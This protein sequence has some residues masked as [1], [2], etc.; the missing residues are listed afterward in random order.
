MNGRAWSHGAI[1]IKLIL[2]APS[3]EKGKSLV[4]YSGGIYDTLDGSSGSTFTY[5]PIAYNDDCQISN[6]IKYKLEIEFLE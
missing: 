6:E 4:D 2:Y 1:S 5:L 3:F